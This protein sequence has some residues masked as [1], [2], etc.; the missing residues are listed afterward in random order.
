VLSRFRGCCGLGHFW[1]GLSRL[2]TPRKW[3]V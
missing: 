3:E 2:F 1:L